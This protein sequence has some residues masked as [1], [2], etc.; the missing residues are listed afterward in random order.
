MKYKTIDREL[1]DKI[2]TMRLDA[3]SKAIRLL[4]IAQLNYRQPLGSYAVSAMHRLIGADAS[5]AIFFILGYTAR[6]NI[7]W[8][9]LLDIS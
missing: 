6:P 3:G 7:D 2:E 4:A 1:V 5:A 9:R 8:Q